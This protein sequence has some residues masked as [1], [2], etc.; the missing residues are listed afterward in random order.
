MESFPRLLL[1]LK[2]DSSVNNPFRQTIKTLVQD[3]RDEWRDEKNFSNEIEKKDRDLESS[4]LTNIENNTLISSTRV[5]TLIR[6]AYPTSFSNEF[7][8]S[9]NYPMQIAEFRK[10]SI[11]CTMLRSEKK[12]VFLNIGMKFREFAILGY[13]K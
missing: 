8:N 5:D 11:I 6:N 1:T 10:I 3:F 12:R 4:V 7:L 2:L 9:K 13:N